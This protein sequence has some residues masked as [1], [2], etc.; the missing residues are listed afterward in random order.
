MQ[1]RSLPPRI[2]IEAERYISARRVNAKKIIHQYSIGSA[3]L[4]SDTYI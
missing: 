3:W 2:H 1:M 4:Q